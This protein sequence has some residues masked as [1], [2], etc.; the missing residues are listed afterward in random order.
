MK[1]LLF[2]SVALLFVWG[3]NRPAAA[4]VTPEKE[5]TVRRAPRQPKPEEI[6][7]SPLMDEGPMDTPSRIAGGSPAAKRTPEAIAKARANPEMIAEIRQ[8][9]CETTLDCPDFTLQ[10]MNDFSLR[11]E[12]RANVDLL[13]TYSGKLTFDPMSRLSPIATAVNFYGMDESYTPDAAAR[14]DEDATELTTR[15]IE[16]KWWGRKNRVTYTNEAKDVVPDGLEQIEAYL[17]KLVEQA[18]WTPVEQ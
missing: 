15:S 10:I 2:L 3:C 9:P 12:G 14:E 13:G 7:E 16:I 8:Y 5:T 18:I 11:Y 4:V 1:N 6:A 17:L